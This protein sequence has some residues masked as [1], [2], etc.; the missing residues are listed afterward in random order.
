MP[1]PYARAAAALLIVAAVLGIA[2]VP[3]VAPT[4]SAL[5]ASGVRTAASGVDFLN[6]SVSDQ[7]AFTTNIG[8]VQPGD[9]VHVTVTQ[10]GTIPHT[11]TLSPTAGYTFPTTDTASDLTAYFSSHAPIVNIQVGATTG[12]KFYANF[13]AP[14]V[15]VYEYVCTEPGHFPSMSG[16]LGSGEAPGSLSTAN[17]PG[18]PVYIISG[19]I[20]GL[21]ILALV[22]GF[23]VGK[24]RGAAEEMPPERLGYPEPTPAPT[25][26]PKAP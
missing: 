22:L 23:V 15:G 26:P 21:V 9:S 2:L 7:L 18:A 19:T 24:R 25:Q 13:T 20:V 3:S 8:E 10:L 14:A 1:R 5:P 4:H 17:G 6:V 16:L 12:A 11:F